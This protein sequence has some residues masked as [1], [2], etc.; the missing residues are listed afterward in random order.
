MGEVTT[1][2]GTHLYIGPA[3]ATAQAD[4]LAEFEAISGWTEIGLVE[5]VGE[6][7]DQSN[8]VTFSAL[9]D[10]RVR[11]SKGA[12]DAGTMAVTTAHDPTDVGQAALEV[13]E[14]TKLNFAFRVDLPDAPGPTYSN[15]QIYFRGLVMSKRKNVGTNDNIIR[16]NYNIGIN[17][18][19]FTDQATT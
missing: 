15:T 2:S 4:T 7:G 10:A 19:L 16:N 9:G 1:A 3:V 14:G 8:E 5:S 13:A 17:S 18:E 6:F 12:R 11:R